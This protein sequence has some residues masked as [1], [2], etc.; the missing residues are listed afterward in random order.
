MSV[1]AIDSTP[2]LIVIHRSRAS[3]FTPI[4]DPN[5]V[6]VAEPLTATKVSLRSLARRWQALTEDLLELDAL[7]TPLVAALNP[8]LLSRNGVA[9]DTAGQL[10]V[11]AGNNSDRLHRERP[12]RAH[13]HLPR[14]SQFRPHAAAPAQ[15]W[16]R[17]ARQRRP[18]PRSALPDALGPP[19]P[20]ST[21]SGVP[22]RA[23][24]RRRSS[25]AS[26]RYLVRELYNVPQLTPHI[27]VPA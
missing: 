15:P 4:V 6:A 5:D 2:A 10:L 7:I 18:L 20:A 24:P 23:C 11:T 27:A 22:T 21:S 14:A 19:A 13:G 16:R 12:R 25:A 3:S 1:R 17:P 8:T 9:A 26:K